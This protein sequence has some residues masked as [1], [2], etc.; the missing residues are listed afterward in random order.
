VVATQDNGLEAPAREVRPGLALV[1]ISAVQLMVI[2]DGTIVNVALPS[3]QRAL[4]FSAAGLEWVIAAYALTFGGL[5]LLGGRSGDLF[6]R[7][8]MFGIGVAIFAGASLLGGLAPGSGWLIAARMLQGVGGAIASP[9]ALALIQ[10]LYPE[11]PA[12]ARALGVYAAMSGAGGS[13]GLLLGGVLT[14][15]VSWRWVFFVN[16][17]IGLVVAFLAPRLLP[18]GETRPGRLDLPGALSVTAGMTS[19]VYGFTRAATS[20]WSNSLTIGA[21]AVGVVLL[22]VFLR[23]EMTSTHALMPLRI[24]ADRGRAGAYAVM[25]GLAA[26]MFGSFFFMSQYVQDVLGYSPLKAGLA[27]LPMTI[28]IGAT[29]NVLARLVGR[30]GTRLPMAIGPAIGASGLFWLSFAGVGSGYASVVGPIVLIA[31]GMGTTFLPLTLTVMSRVERHEAGLASALLNA[32]QQIGG[33]LGLAVLVTVATSVT[34]AKHAALTAAAAA[35]GLVVSQPAAA[36]GIAHQALTSGYDAG[37]R[38]AAVIALGSFVVA[39][40]VARTRRQTPADAPVVEG[41]VQLEVAA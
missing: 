19:L 37:F 34:A 8:R 5:L 39:A 26:G 35:H 10:N 25:L 31:V 9:T 32:A 28:G 41:Q 36:G 12:R 24:F 15:L 17:P 18:A 40:L 33:S 30:T 14:D 11:G 38:I 2:L 16:V 29:A 23:I 20:G 3:I 13:L 4:H 7:R 6:G 22:A 27:F 21:L 1:L